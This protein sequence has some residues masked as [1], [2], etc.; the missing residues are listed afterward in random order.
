MH[1]ISQNKEAGRKTERHPLEK[2]SVRVSQAE[3][4]R[5][6]AGGWRCLSPALGLRAACQVISL[7]PGSCPVLANRNCK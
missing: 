7:N 1:L 3:A 6:L 5:C 4:A 2:P